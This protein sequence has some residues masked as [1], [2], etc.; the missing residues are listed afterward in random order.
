[1]YFSLCEKPRFF[2]GLI[3]DRVQALI[4]VC[5]AFY[6]GKYISMEEPKKSTGVKKVVWW[7]V[8]IILLLALL[9]AVGLRVPA[10]KNA[11]GAGNGTRFA[12]TVTV[13]GEKVIYNETVEAKEG[14]ALI[15]VMKRCITSNGGVVYEDSEYGAYITGICGYDQ[16]PD[17]G[18]YW[19]YT[20]N[21][22]Y[23]MVGASE[24]IP[25]ADDDICFDLSAM[26]W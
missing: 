24:Y 6:E 16:D 25:N 17:T 5:T 10:V 21:G 4:I 18:K 2:A 20:V 9:A 13:D 1:M 12:L 23:A 26:E 7:V 22:D 14:E 19:T 3:T 11:I 15:D 8:G